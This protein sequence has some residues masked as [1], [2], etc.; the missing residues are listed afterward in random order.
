MKFFP[1][2]FR[3][4]EKGFIPAE[5]CSDACTVL[6]E[7]MSRSQLH[8]YCIGPP[9]EGV[10]VAENWTCKCGRIGVLKWNNDRYNCP[11]CKREFQC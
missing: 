3:G 1:V 4:I 5:T 7:V 6:A 2:M 9:Q 8:S 11:D 10:D